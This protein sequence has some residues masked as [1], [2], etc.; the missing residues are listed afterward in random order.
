MR[1]N[2]ALRFYRMKRSAVL[3]TGGYGA[4]TETRYGFSLFFT[5]PEEFRHV[6][7]R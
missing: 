3:Q 5:P 2:G 1:P 7:R 6:Q 4:G